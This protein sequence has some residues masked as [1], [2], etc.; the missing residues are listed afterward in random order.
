MSRKPKLVVLNATENRMRVEVKM[1]DGS[2][3]PAEVNTR[4]CRPMNT[5]DREAL[6][7]LIVAARDHHLQLNAPPT[8]ERTP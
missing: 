2:V 5:M 3:I 4:G 7:A 6:A 8:P 1:P